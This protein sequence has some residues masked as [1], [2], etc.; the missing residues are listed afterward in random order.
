MKICLFDWNAGG[1]HNVYA[2]AFAAALAPR[3]EVVVAGPDPLLAD[4][5]DL[6][7]EAHSLG[8]PRPRPD[9]GESKGALAER[10][11]ELLRGAIESSRPDHAV[12]L[13]A[14][15]T[16]RWLARAPR[17]PSRISVIVMLAKAHF[18]AA[19]GISLSPRER[20]SARFKEWSIRRW[21]QRPDSH[22]LFGVDAEAARRWARQPGA[23]AR[24][25]AEPRPEF[26]P[27]VKAAAERNGCFMFGYLDERKGIDRLADALSSGCE[28]LE[29][30]LFGEVAPE[31][32][33]QLRVDLERLRE[34]G[35]RLRTDLRRVPYEA[36]L[37]EMARAR[38]ALL[39][40]G[41][42]PP[43]SRVLLEA[44]LVRT[45]VAVGEDSA[46]GH[47][48]ERHGLGVTADPRDPGA[49]REAILSVALDPEAPDR[50]EERL[51]RYAEE[52]HGERFAAQV[53]DTFGV[54]DD[55]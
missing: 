42:R 43:A 40:F 21:R 54:G 50:H 49:L 7:V 10:E 44:A 2:R 26:V 31:Y 48:V 24:W 41:W 22:A 33:D 4:L 45:P 11:L 6:P 14:D 47:L 8:E 19:Y 30:T 15:P 46:V 5:G 29:L 3:A 18:P 16:L 20:L 36:A 53:R 51:R 23:T 34:G 12:L 39:S 17:F 35:V 27:P 37:E 28:G 25:L 1:H 32:R 55:E 52:V 38:C 13:F 9:Y